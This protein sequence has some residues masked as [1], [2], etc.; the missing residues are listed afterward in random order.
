MQQNLISNYYSLNNVCKNYITFGNALLTQFIETRWFETITAPHP[1][2]IAVVKVCFDPIKIS[3]KFVR[4]FKA[5]SL[6]CCFSYFQIYSK[7]IC[8]VGDIF[9]QVY[10]IT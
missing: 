7:Q 9:S 8:I 5:I 1:P 10:S 4:A 6:H 3:I 2:F